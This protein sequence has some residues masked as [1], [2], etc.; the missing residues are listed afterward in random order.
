MRVQVIHDHHG[1]LRLGVVHVRQRLYLHREIHLGPMR[2]H[3][4]FSLAI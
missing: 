2:S 3:I 1:A 4:H